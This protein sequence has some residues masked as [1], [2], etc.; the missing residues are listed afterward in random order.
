MTGRHGRPLPDARRRFGSARRLRAAG[1][2]ALVALALVGAACSSS[3]SGGASGSSG[4]S[5][6]EAGPTSTTAG[7][8]TASTT[9]P[10]SS[11]TVP[12][13]STTAGGA[14][15]STSGTVAEVEPIGGYPVGR[16]Q[17]DL[18]DASRDTP[19][20]GKAP[21]SKGR[22][23]PTVAFYP[24]EGTAPAGGGTPSATAG[25]PERDGRYPLLVFS[26]GVTARGI[27][28][29][30]ELA[31]FAS[32]GYVVVAPDYP[33]S[34]RNSP[35]GPTIA[36]VGNQPADA[37]FLIDTFTD[38]AGSG[39]AAAVAAHVDP[40]HIGAVGH[41][42]GAITSLGLG[43]STCCT[44][45]RVAAVASWAGVFLPLRGRPS[46]KPGITD[47]PLLLIHG[48]E[49]RTVPYG[50]SVSAFARV[51]SPR[52]FITLPGQGHT[53]PFLTPGSSPVARLAT[54]ATVD[55][56][57]AELKGD[58]GG[59]AALTAAVDAAGPDVATLQSAGS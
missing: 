50:S 32:A 53:P 52:W 31:A 47:R 43:Y 59:I 5:T 4:S 1:L 26:H 44:D 3:D 2:V 45:D 29:A 22:K 56:F 40:R 35:G 8:S 30:G 21:G 19:A 33:L 57:D 36:D 48:D 39:P 13:S 24:A 14:A 38:A 34:N 54:T 25:A 18:V 37:S 17:V 58:D 11:T 51:E 23:L 49:D 16:V 12:G 42:L 9:E 41:S 55:F 7:G 27:F 15:G 6:T 10:G 46:P 28:Y 20:N